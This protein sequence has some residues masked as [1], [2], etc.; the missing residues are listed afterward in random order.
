M[1]SRVTLFLLLLG[2]MLGLGI[3][4]WSEGQRDACAPYL[5]GNKSAMASEYVPSGTRLIAV[6]CRDWIMRQSLRIQILCLLDLVLAALFVL[7]ALADLQAWLRS[8]RRYR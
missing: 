6:P 3:R 7:N 8:R 1:I 4:L 5:E 2:L